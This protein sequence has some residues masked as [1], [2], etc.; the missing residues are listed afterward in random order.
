LTRW[1]RRAAIAAALAAA[2]FVGGLYVDT[3][4]DD[5]YCPQED[6]CWVDYDG[7]NNRWVVHEQHVDDAP[8]WVTD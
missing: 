3:R 4:S 1:L 2:G 7:A 8:A 6:S 5:A